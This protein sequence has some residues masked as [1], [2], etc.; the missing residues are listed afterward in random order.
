MSYDAVRTYT[1]KKGV[2]LKYLWKWF[3]N[4]M[5]EFENPIWRGFKDV[6][7]EG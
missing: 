7:G 2:G 5:M 6:V 1:K 3:I 4:K